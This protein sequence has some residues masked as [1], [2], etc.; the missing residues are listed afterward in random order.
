MVDVILPLLIAISPISADAPTDKSAL[1]PALPVI[2]VD[3]A[4][5]VPVVDRLFE[6]KLIP[7]PEETTEP[8]LNVRFPT[9]SVLA[10]VV[11]PSIDVA[12]ATDKVEPI[13]V[14]ASILAVVTMFPLVEILVV[15]NEIVPSVSVILPFAIVVLPALNEPPVTLLVVEILLPIVRVS[16]AVVILPVVNVISPKILPEDASIEPLIS[17]PFD[18]I[19]P[20]ASYITAFSDLTTPGDTPT[21]LLTSAATSWVPVKILRLDGVAVNVSLP[22]VNDVPVIAPALKSPLTAILL[23]VNV[24]ISILD[25][26]ILSWLIS[27]LSTAILPAVT[28]SVVVISD[29]VLIV[30]KLVSMEPAVNVPTVDI[31]PAPV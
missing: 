9:L 29:S 28:F 1:M 14:S 30:P 20:A 3:P 19:L 16:V 27:K 26:W 31:V 15:P 12:P 11:T 23:V 24:K 17:N 7:G 8:E 13:N 25:N 21:S 10:T 4:E 18:A 2:F 22:I 5:R 6:L